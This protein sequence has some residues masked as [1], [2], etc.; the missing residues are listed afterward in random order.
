VSAKH[1]VVTCE[2]K[3]AEASPPELEV[4]IV[5]LSR[6]GVTLNGVKL[7]KDEYVALK[8]GDV[9]TLPFHLEYRFEL[10]PEGTPPRSTRALLNGAPTPLQ[11]K[12]RSPGAS[13]G[14]GREDG[15]NS[16]RAR[17]ADGADAEALREA[18]EANETLR[19]RVEELEKALEAEAVAERRKQSDETNDAEVVDELERKLAS[20]E[21]RAV[22]A[23]NELDEA[24]RVV[25]NAAAATK[26]LETKLAETTASKATLETS[27][28]VAEARRVEEIEMLK[29]E[30]ASVVESL[31][32]RVADVVA[33][34]APL[35]E[36]LARAKAQLEKNGHVV[37]ESHELAKQLFDKLGESVRATASVSFGDDGDDDETTREKTPQKD[38]AADDGERPSGDAADDR[39]DEMDQGNTDADET[40]PGG[41]AG[42]DAASPPLR[43]IGNSPLP[44]SESNKRRGARDSEGVIPM[45]VLE[46]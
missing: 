40:T 3:D 5:D 41:K 44:E 38:A 26:E 29:S 27:L 45:N 19:R 13:V 18:S 20:A 31:N 32:A 22:E 4:K 28:E 9:V 43:S 46:D 37:R 23:E 11:L 35:K 24:K 30:H 15:S 8:D 34:T 25:E 33:E 2:V 14:D 16:K 7:K 36:S 21:E 39:N 12:K 1:A 6:N 42:G 17:G 10:N